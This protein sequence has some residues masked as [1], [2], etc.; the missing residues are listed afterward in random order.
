MGLLSFVLVFFSR[1]LKLKAGVR[2]FEKKI[3]LLEKKRK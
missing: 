2:R 1:D 3:S